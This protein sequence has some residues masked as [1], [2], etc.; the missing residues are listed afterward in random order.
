[1]GPTDIQKLLGVGRPSL[2]SH[3]GFAVFATSRPDIAANSAVGQLWRVDLPDGAPRRLTRGK[4]DG[5]PRLSPDGAIGVEIGTRGREDRE[6][7]RG[8][9]RGPTDPD[10]CLEVGRPH[11]HSFPNEPVSPTRRVWS[12]GAGSTAA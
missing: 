2:A 3:G 4:A 10:Q 1:M 6:D 9:D 11:A 7:P 8:G 5:A 12:A